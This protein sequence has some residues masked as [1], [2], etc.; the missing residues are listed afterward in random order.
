MSGVMRKQACFTY[1]KTK[2]QISCAVTG[3]LISAFVLAAQIVQLLYFLNPKF[4]LSSQ[5]LSLYSSV[6]V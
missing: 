4:Q 5:L 1:A 2:T 3:Q 6:C